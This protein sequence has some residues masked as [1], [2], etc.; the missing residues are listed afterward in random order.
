[1][2]A[3]GTSFLSGKLHFLVSSQVLAN[4]MSVALQPSK[5]LHLSSIHSIPTRPM[6]YATRHPSQRDQ[7]PPPL[8]TTISNKSHDL[9]C[10]NVKGLPTGSRPRFCRI[11]FYP[12]SGTIH[13]NW[14]EGVVKRLSGEGRPTGSRS[15]RCFSLIWEWRALMVRWKR[16]QDFICQLLGAA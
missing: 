15:E 16:S 10:Q 5:I 6:S 2:L 9:L 13:S 14:A 7:I 11:T 3:R 12:R 4:V 8:P 1:M